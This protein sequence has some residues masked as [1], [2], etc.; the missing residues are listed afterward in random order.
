MTVSIGLGRVGSKFFFI[1]SGL[2]WVSKLM[3]LVGS[4]HTKWTHGQLCKNS[5]GRGPTGRP[6]RPVCYLL[7]NCYSPISSSYT[8]SELRGDYVVQAD[9]INSFQNRLDKYWANQEVVFNFNWELI[10]TRGL[11]VCM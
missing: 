11:P 3:G 1:C 6:L 10:G 9:S 8:Q 5:S 4:G 2:G 7:F